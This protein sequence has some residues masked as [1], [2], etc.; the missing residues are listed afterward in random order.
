MDL[1]IECL[2]DQ[3]IA[4]GIVRGVLLVTVAT[5]ILVVPLPFA[6]LPVFARDVHGA[7]E[8]GLAWLVAASGAGTLL[9]AA[10]VAARGT[11]GQPGRWLLYSAVVLA[12]SVLGL[13]AEPW[14]ALAVAAAVVAG[15]AGSVLM[16]M[17]GAVALLAVP[18]GMRGQASGWLTA[19][20]ATLP[21]GMLLLGA[22]AA[23]VGLTATTVIAGCCAATLLFAVSRRA[24]LWS[25]TEPDR[26]SDDAWVENMRSAGR[27]TRTRRSRAR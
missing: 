27:H 20:N 8:I 14:F 9:G 15:A 19:A 16:T 18:P 4:D 13:A 21:A 10:A 7:G 1:K 6:F 17:Q 22:T 12:V 3:D 26:A 23:A 2:R 24:N 5:N 11:V 25:A